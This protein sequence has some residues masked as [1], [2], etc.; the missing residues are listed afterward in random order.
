MRAITYS[1]FGPASDVLSLTN[2][3]T[4]SPATGEVLVRLRKSGVNPSDAKAR[5]G[6]RP[7]VTKPAFDQIIPHS[8]GAGVIETVGDGVDA[9]RIGQRVWIWNG[10]WQRAFGT[11]AEY[12]A[13]P[14]AQAI[15][16]PDGISFD[17]GATLGIPGLTAAHTV[18]GGGDVAGQTMLISGG[19]GAVGHNA[20]QL[21][22]SGGATVIATCSDQAAQRVRDAGADHVF[23]YA[24]PDLAAQIT[25]AT[26]GAGINRAVEVE[27]GVNA[28]LLAEVMAPNGTIAAYG[29]FID[30][31]PELPFGPYLFKALKIDITLIY[32]LPEPKRDAA[33]TRLHAALKDGALTPAIHTTYPLVDCADAHEA[34]MSAG[35]AGAVLLDLD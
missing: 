12:I 26:S 6:A 3:P 2:L 23:N 32:I 29:S 22:K 4:P 21:A 1:S 25:D 24:D 16:L 7:G 27:F 8:D 35:R 28:A 13:L 9:T 30:M 33:I 18:F 11:A 20:V 17:I 15:P 5:A 19:A 31:T 34:V 14:A 10:Q